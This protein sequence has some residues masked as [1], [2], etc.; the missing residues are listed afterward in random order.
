MCEYC[1]SRSG[2]YLYS[3]VIDDA[4]AWVATLM[5]TDGLTNQQSTSKIKRLSFRSR[6]T[7]EATVEGLR[8]F[9]NLN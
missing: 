6:T 5:R 8:L 7:N 9:H 2:S 1:I 4:V 3:D